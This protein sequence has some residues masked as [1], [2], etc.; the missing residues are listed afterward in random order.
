[1]HQLMSQHYF[2]Q[3]GGIIRS[4]FCDRYLNYSLAVQ[5]LPVYCM[6]TLI[7]DPHVHKTMCMCVF[8]KADGYRYCV[9]GS[10]HQV[11]LLGMGTGVIV[12]SSITDI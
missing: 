5:D 3:C 12:S 4:F 6:L 8:W 9:P 2:L 10:E 1:M 11:S 7:D